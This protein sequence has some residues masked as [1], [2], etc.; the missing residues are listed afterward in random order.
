MTEHYG[1]RP[2]IE[3]PCRVVKDEVEGYRAPTDLDTNPWGG[4]IEYVNDLWRNTLVN[5]YFPGLA[6][7]K[8]MNLC[9]TDEHLIDAMSI[10]NI[11]Q[12]RMTGLDVNYEDV[13]IGYKLRQKTEQPILEFR[14]KYSPCIKIVITAKERG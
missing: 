9:G 7:N 4:K 12:K 13:E 14:G 10:F 2:F 1:W 6:D 3:I 8:Q 5:I 11:M